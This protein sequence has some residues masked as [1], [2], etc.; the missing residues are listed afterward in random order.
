MSNKAEAN[1]M[2]D[3][4]KPELRP[5]LRFPEFRDADGWEQS[6]LRSLLDY[7]RPDAYIVSDTDYNT[8]GTPVLTANKSFVL[9][10]TNETTGIFSATPVIIFD[11]F[12]TDKKFR[13]LSVQSEVICHQDFKEQ[14]RR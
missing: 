7:E 4:S 13:G 3:N 6:P 9:G 12:T 10:Y 1:T 11:D 8:S 2:K 14:T 5:K